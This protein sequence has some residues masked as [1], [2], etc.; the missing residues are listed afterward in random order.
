MR[1]ILIVDDDENIRIIFRKV[2]ENAGYEVD[3]APNGRVA[4]EKLEKKE[5]DVYLLD[6]KMPEMDG[7][8]LLGEI[9]KRGYEGIPIILTAYGDKESAINALKLGAYDFVE[10]PISINDLRFAIQRAIE[11]KILIE[12]NIRL[13]EVE[14]INR[15]V[16]EIIK[17]SNEEEF[18]KKLPHLLIDT[19]NFESAMVYIYKPEEKVY[20]Y[21][22][23]IPEIEG[24]ID[25]IK[26]K[27]FL[28]KDIYMFQKISILEETEGIIGVKSFFPFIEREI[29]TF[30]L[31]CKE[32]EIFWKHLLSKEKLRE[33]LNT[34]KNY[35]LTALRTGRISILGEIS[36]TLIK[37]IEEPLSRIEILL[38]YFFNKEE[39]VDLK[40]TKDLKSSWDELKRVINNFKNLI[41]SIKPSRKRVDLGEVINICYEIL[42]PK[43][44]EN[45]VSFWREGVESL[46]IEGYPGLLE[47]IFINLFLNSLDVLKEGGKIGVRVEEDEDFV[48]IEV[49]DTGPG[50]PSNIKN[51]IFEPFF[52]TK[53]EGTGMGLALVKHAVEMHGGKISFET[54]EGVGTTF[55]IQL[56][57]KWGG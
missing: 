10:K 15:V 11:R 27:D 14:K 7:I 29:E 37:E 28:I 52:T 19:L 23:F 2:L 53:K 38:S 36:N 12:E 24:F 20:F 46:E 40:E 57:K 22:R 1:K 25:E 47:Q 33:T 48:K 35:H 9:N 5:F 50:I 3:T 49:S 31:I 51:R 8:T 34:L 17:C 4:L 54:E 45:N 30:K 32:S 39:L 26:E 55:Y 43:F 41:S 21:P 44:I 42:L 13:K 18:L 6:L 16:G 56:P